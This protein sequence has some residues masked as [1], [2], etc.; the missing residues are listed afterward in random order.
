MTTV[1]CLLQ[2]EGTDVRRKFQFHGRS[3]SITLRELKESAL[4][5]R[6]IGGLVSAADVTFKVRFLAS[7][8]V[9]RNYMAC[10][11]VEHLKLRMRFGLS[12]VIVSSV[13]SGFVFVRGM[14]LTLAGYVVCRPKEA[15]HLSK[16]LCYSLRSDVLLVV[17][18]TAMVRGMSC[19][20]LV[21][22]TL[23]QQRVPTEKQ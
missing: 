1:A 19:L 16:H 12:H 22:L 17:L 21:L 2:V 7:L 23:P 9:K 10:N 14:L 3:E 11:T 4:K 13:V 20:T 8:F 6:L 5:C 15:N 18:A